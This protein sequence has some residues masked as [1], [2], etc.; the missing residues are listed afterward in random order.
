MEENENE[1]RIEE[2]ILVIA[3]KQL[4]ENN[5]AETKITLDRLMAT[6]ESR[7]NAMRYISTVLSLEV[8]EMMKDKVVFNEERYV[9]KLR[10]L[11]ELPDE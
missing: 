7:E 11:P 10:A 5:P 3:E 2:A 8:F 6:G 4:K 9:N 1:Q